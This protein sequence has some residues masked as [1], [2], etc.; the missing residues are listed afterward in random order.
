MEVNFGI[1]RPQ[2]IGII[3]GC[4]VFSLTIMTVVVLLFKSGTMQGFFEQMKR[5]ADEV[6]AGE[7]DGR[8]P[9]DFDEGETPELYDEL[10]EATK[11]LPLEPCL[12]G[13]LKARTVRCRSLIVDKDSEKVSKF[14]DG[15]AR[16]HAS[17]YNARSI[18]K[19]LSFDQVP[20]TDIGEGE[21]GVDTF[22]RCYGAN[23]SK[24]VHVVVEDEELSEPVGMLSLVDNDPRNLTIRIDNLWI[25]PA[26][27]SS[28]IVTAGASLDLAVGKVLTDSRR[29]VATE[30]LYAVLRWLFED[31]HY[32]RVTVEV[33]TR[34]IIMCKLMTSS[35]FLLEA[36]LR[37]HRI[38]NKRN[39]DSALYVM[40]NSDWRLG[41]KTALEA[42]IGIESKKT[43]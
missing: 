32:R 24:G 26:Y 3:A 21:E 41:A 38:V 29:R 8:P 35:G 28:N 17:A 18:W 25:T 37:K 7:K 30:A 40:L 27:R 12:P 9:D 43:K 4:I 22:K 31:C 5:E 10:M 6:K 13:H 34:H 14:C 36:T 1:K 39:R 11:T 19:R 23:L 2:M 20:G 15:S 42:T 16:F 33:D